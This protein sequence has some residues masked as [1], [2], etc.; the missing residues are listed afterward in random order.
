M[1]DCI[2]C[3]STCFERPTSCDY[4]DGKSVGDLLEK[5][6]SLNSNLE[7]LA[8]KVVSIEKNCPKCGVPTNVT[9]DTSVDSEVLISSDIR[10]GEV[11][12]SGNVGNPY[13]IEVTPSESSTTINY[14]FTDSIPSDCE[15][16]RSSVF[17]ENNSGN[18]VK[19]SSNIKDYI[20]LQPKDFPA[21]VTSD[22]IIN[23]DNG[24]ETI[25]GRTRIS[26]ENTSYVG[27]FKSSP[28]SYN[29]PT[30]QEE[31][32][33]LFD[34]KICDIEGRLNSYIGSD[35]LQLVNELK[36]K[37]ES[38]EE[39]LSDIG[40]LVVSYQNECDECNPGTI[41]ESLSAALKKAADCCCD[42]K[43]EIQNNNNS[44]SVIEGQYQTINTPT[45]TG[46]GIDTGGDNTGDQDKLVYTC[47]EV[48]VGTGGCTTGPCEE[49]VKRCVQVSE[50][51]LSSTEVNY[52]TDNTCGGGC[53][54]NTNL[55]EQYFLEDLV[56][57]GP[58][59]YDESNNTVSYTIEST[60]S[61]PGI[62]I[63]TSPNSFICNSTYTASIAINFPTGEVCTYNKDFGQT[64]DCV[65]VDNP[66]EGVTIDIGVEYTDNQLIVDVLSGGTGPFQYYIN[67]SLSTL[68]QENLPDG[69]YTVYVIDAQG[70]KSRTA[71]FTVTTEPTITWRCTTSGECVQAPGPFTSQLDCEENCTQ[72]NPD[73]VSVTVSNPNTQ[74]Q[75]P[76]MLG[77]SYIDCITGQT[78]SGSLNPQD[79]VTLCVEFPGLV[80]TEDNLNVLP[81]SSCN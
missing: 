46:G 55:C 35:I 69:N 30:N 6:K 47:R 27:D 49:K 77:Y 19:R 64:P 37:V 14:D 31:V 41:T 24:A 73:C 80:E 68:P 3:P 16:L 13:S 72:A 10:C 48:S 53:D 29:K 5:G 81:G 45:G 2:N 1:S 63:T 4:Y 70:C 50:T 40:S 32:N 57:I 11:R 71:N 58:I 25:T 28:K 74:S 75:N 9:K 18:V 38:L 76:N 42:N 51:T 21:Y 67:G 22:I 20:N 26:N 36:S 62:S 33:T 7:S 66:C 52:G 44:I 34:D 61:V 23:T 65:T 43:A 56:I 15:V 12:S 8:E 54:N 79:Q 17:V 78:I 59:S 39:R 60:G